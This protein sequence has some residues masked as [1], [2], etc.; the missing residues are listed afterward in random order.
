MNMDIY[1]ALGS[2]RYILKIQS[3]RGIRSSGWKRQEAGAVLKA[4]LPIG[5]LLTTCGP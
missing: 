2:D 1:G 4:E 3:G 5:S